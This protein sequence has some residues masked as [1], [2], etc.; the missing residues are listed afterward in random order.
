VEVEDSGAFGCPGWFPQADRWIIWYKEGS[1]FN[2]HAMRPR[3]DML[4]YKGGD[5]LSF[6][7]N[8]KDVQALRAVIVKDRKEVWD[9]VRGT[10]EIRVY[11][12]AE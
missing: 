7:A 9:I 1:S 2:Y 4:I 6:L 11:E 8:T 3:Q 12:D 5:V 10:G